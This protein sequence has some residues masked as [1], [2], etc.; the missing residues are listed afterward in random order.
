MDRTAVAG[1][2]MVLEQYSFFRESPAE[3]KADI[4]SR[5][6]EAKVPLGT[7]LF[8]RGGSCKDIALFGA[9]SVR[10]F[11]GN[12]AGREVT[13][14]HVGPGET[15]PCNLLGALQ[16]RPVP[17]TAVVEAEVHAVLLPGAVFRDWMRQ[18]ESVRSFL[19]DGLAGRFV[20]VFDHVHE[21]SFCKLDERLADFLMKRF[22]ES[23]DSPP[24]VVGTHEQVASELSTAREVVSRLLRDFERTGAVDLGRGRITLRNAE[25]LA[26]YQR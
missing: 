1:K 13:L 25:L 11:I 5:A 6:N 9:G 23:H 16:G 26:Q 8:D 14:Y 22:A 19:I 4:V 12:E 10:V 7:V 24:S 3:L 18:H 20:E 21:V 15:C 17:A 2:L